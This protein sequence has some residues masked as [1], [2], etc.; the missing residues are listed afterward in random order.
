MARL[1]RIT[2]TVS[3]TSS[4]TTAIPLDTAHPLAVH[5]IA[6]A[7]GAGIEWVVQLVDVGI[8]EVTP[9]DA[10]PDDWRFRSAD[11]Q[12]ALEARRLERD[13]GVELDAAALILDLQREVR[14]LRAALHARGLGGV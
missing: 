1:S 13:F 11:L 5:E 6:H 8:V 9:P 3:S 10:K 4:S 2:T 14:H 7:C 12:R